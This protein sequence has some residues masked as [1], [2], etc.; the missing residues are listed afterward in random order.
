[1]T[2]YYLSMGYGNTYSTGTLD[3]VPTL[4]MTEDDLIS[5]G[6]FYISD[7][8]FDYDT[9][10]DE[11]LEKLQDGDTLT[12]IYPNQAALYILDEWSED[13]HIPNNQRE[14]LW[15]S[16]GNVETYIHFIDAEEENWYWLADAQVDHYDDNERPVP[17]YPADEEA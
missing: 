5:D 13:F 6:E 2:N 11:A 1:M 10:R 3:N 7:D 14:E 8:P 17:I 15:N 16:E 12:I 9:V 4:P